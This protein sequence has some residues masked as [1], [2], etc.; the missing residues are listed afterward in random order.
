M[1]PNK[2]NGTPEQ[3][4]A[5]PKPIPEGYVAVDNFNINHDPEDLIRY[6][7]NWVAWSRD[8]RKVLFASPDPYKLCEMVDAAGLKPGDYVFDGLDVP[9]T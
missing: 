8:G 2:T 5:T 1:P 3:P 7:G 9:W 6:R 4:A